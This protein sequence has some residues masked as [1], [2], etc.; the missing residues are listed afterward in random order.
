LW[1]FT[2]AELAGNNLSFKDFMS[3]PIETHPLKNE[4]Q[5]IWENLSRFSGFP[6]PYIGED[7]QLYRIW[8]NT[9]K[10][11][12]LRDDIRDSTSIRNIEDVELLFSLLPSKIGSPLSMANLSRDLKVSFDS[13]RNWIE[14]FENYFLIFRL[15]PWRKKITRAIT[16]EKKLYFYNYAD[17][18]SSSA[19]FENMVALELRRG[20]TNW[21]DLGLGNYSLHYIRNRDKEEVDFLVANNNNPLILIETKMSDD[22]PTKSLRKFQNVLNIPAIQLVNKPDISKLVSNGE[23]KILVIS[24]DHWL[25]LL[26]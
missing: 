14:I 12:L 16:K 2:L 26:P 25:S 1:P 19:K 24:A 23:N 15:S 10:R 13:I 3:N 22:A 18:E 5:T 17:I 8:S 9:Y 11:Q 7:G 21:N 4:T 6:D 20:V